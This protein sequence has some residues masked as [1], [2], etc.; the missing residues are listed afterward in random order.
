MPGDPAAMMAMMQANMAMFQAQ[1]Q[2]AAGAAAALPTSSGGGSNGNGNQTQQQPQHQ[3][4]QAGAVAGLGGPV[5]TKQEPGVPL[6][7]PAGA[8]G[9][10]PAQLTAGGAGMRPQQL[11]QGPTAN[12]LQQH[13][14][15]AA[16]AAMGTSPDFS[17]VF[18]D[19]FDGQVTQAGPAAALPLPS[20]PAA[21]VAGAAGGPD[22]E[23]LIDFIL[24]V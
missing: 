8:I 6:Q 18:D 19:V 13:P 11:Q 23:F 4:Q 2:A 15:S 12:G 7:S 21:V 5:L 9:G 1:Q 17:R 16:A 20:A 24:K 10:L 14:A 22:D 3:Q